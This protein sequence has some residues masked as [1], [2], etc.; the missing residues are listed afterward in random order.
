[1]IPLVNHMREPTDDQ[2]GDTTGHF[3]YKKKEINPRLVGGS[4]SHVN[5]IG[6]VIMAK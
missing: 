4:M 3:A 5:L 2:P 6:T 1:M